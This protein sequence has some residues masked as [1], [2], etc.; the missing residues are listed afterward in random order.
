MNQ[1]NSLGLSLCFKDEENP[2]VL[3]KEWF[4]EAKKYEINDPNA[5][6][7]ATVAIGFGG[8]MTYGQTLGLTQDLPLIG[9]LAA[10][11]WGLI[12]TFIKGAI[13]IGFFGLFLWLGL[14]V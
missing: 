11:R 7:L 5:V 4:E 8:A 13:W 14:I 3:F 12:G 1:K 9:N 2:V 6:A 10:L